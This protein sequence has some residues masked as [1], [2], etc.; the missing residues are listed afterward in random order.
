MI[1]RNRA[2]NLNRSSRTGYM[3]EKRHGG[4]NSMTAGIVK[5]A[6]RDGYHQ[7]VI[8]S[9]FADNQGRVSEIKTGKAYQ[10]V[11]VSESLPQ[12]FPTL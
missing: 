2:V 3:N 11:P 9:Y 6:L 12:D 10:D 4:I 8:A 1:R 7:H 5:R